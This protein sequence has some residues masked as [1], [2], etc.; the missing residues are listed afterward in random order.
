MVIDL[1]AHEAYA[2]TNQGIVHPKEI[3]FPEEN[4]T[5]L[6]KYNESFITLQNGRNLG[7]ALIKEGD[8][9]NIAAMDSDLAGSMLKRMFYQEGAGLK[10]FKKFSDERTIFGSRVIVWKV[11]WDGIDNE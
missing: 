3:S 2:E 8:D 9:Y 1:K 5:F 11:D 6:K 10:Y 7:V 4:I